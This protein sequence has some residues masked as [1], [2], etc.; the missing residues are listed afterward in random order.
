MDKLYSRQLIERVHA[1]NRSKR[2]EIGIK[3]EKKILI[4]LSS[5]DIAPHP[6]EVISFDRV[7]KVN[8]ETKPFSHTY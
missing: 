1:R 7:V 3:K 4:N 5:W 2:Y 6:T 8:R